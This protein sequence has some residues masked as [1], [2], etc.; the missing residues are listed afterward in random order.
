MVETS[1]L[2]TSDPCDV[3]SVCENNCILFDRCKIFNNSGIMTSKKSLLL[4]EDVLGK[5]PEPRRSIFIYEWLQSL[6]KVIFS[7]NTGSPKFS[8]ELT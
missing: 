2:V 4:N 6:I 5:L 3:V 7:K 8:V 1:I